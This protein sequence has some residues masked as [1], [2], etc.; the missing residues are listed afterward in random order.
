MSGIRDILQTE[1]NRTA[2]EQFRQM[3]LYQ[4]GTFYRAYEHS[5]F[6]CHKFVKEF[7]PTHRTMKGIEGSVVFVGFP[8]TGLQTYL[9]PGMEVA[10]IEEKHLMVTIQPFGEDVTIESLQKD[11]QDWK[12]SIPLTESKPKGGEDASTEGGGAVSSSVAKNP[13]GFVSLTSVARQ[14]MVFPLES[15]SPLECYA[16][17]SCLKKQLA[18]LF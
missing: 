12:A 10:T 14:I 18:S 2:A 16:F 8:V 17:I 5:A 3:H 15:K 6:L 9:K 1:K 13:D 7:K 4:E 11:L